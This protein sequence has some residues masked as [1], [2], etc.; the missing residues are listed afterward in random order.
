MAAAAAQARPPRPQLQ[1]LKL[2]NF[3]VV[4]RSMTSALPIKR[5]PIPGGV[6]TFGNRAGWV[7]PTGRANA[8]HHVVPANA[9]THSHRC[10]LLESRLAPAL[11]RE[12]AAPQ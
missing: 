2:L 10:Q 11:D 9:G 12:A 5:R 1:E 3:S 4:S 7:E 6:F 8:R